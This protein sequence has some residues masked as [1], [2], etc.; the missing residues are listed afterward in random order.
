[1]DLSFTSP[2]YMRT[3]DTENPLSNYAEEGSRSALRS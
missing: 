2:P 3:F 1:M